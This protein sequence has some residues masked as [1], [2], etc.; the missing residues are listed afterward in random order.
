MTVPMNDLIMRTTEVTAVAAA[1]NFDALLRSL[2]VEQ[3]DHLSPHQEDRH[4]EEGSDAW[5][6]PIG[7]ALRWGRSLTGPLAGP[8]TAL[9]RQRGAIEPD[10]AVEW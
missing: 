1:E 8:V 3:N 4:Q 5:S 10:D 6:D 7:R 2:P 9:L